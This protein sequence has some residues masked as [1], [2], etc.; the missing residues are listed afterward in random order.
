M[1]EPIRFNRALFEGR[2]LQYL[3]A[4]ISGGH[5]SGGGPFTRAVEEL[6]SDGHDGAT[7]LLTT[8]CTHALELS[9]LLLELK[10]G[11]E[12][13][14]P[15]FTFV[16][17]ASAFLLHG[18]KPVFADVKQDTLNLDVDQL[19]RVRTPRTRAVCTVNYAGVGADLE[20]LASYCHQHELILIEDNAHGLYGRL[21]GQTL[22]TFGS[23]STL[24]FHETKNLTCGEGGALIIND[25]SLIDRAEILREKGTDRS[26]FFRG[27]VDKYTWVDVGSSWVL[28]DMLAG[29]L[30]GQLER[31]EV[32][33]VRRREIWDQYLGGLEVWAEREGV[34]L[35]IPA[36]DAQHTAHVFHLRTK[37]GGERDRFIA[38]LKDHGVH[39][40]FH[41]QAL[42]LSRVGQQ[43]GG[44]PGQFPVTEDASDTLVRLPLHL[45][46]TDEDVEQ[47]IDVVTGF[48]TRAVAG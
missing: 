31:F 4:A 20:R 43:L 18:G 48:R 10:E 3:Q 15:A 13:I 33:Q 7:A 27:E 12:V 38:R 46:L 37:D 42:H 34:R 40:V 44:R 26:R 5:V 14:V 22:G 25:A 30:L 6:L 19:D 29:I 11:D 39:A 8:S 21:G 28:S 23:L 24:S 9:A 36:K 16:S 41:Y 35:P 45:A 32:I 47:V 1:G 2:E 17:T